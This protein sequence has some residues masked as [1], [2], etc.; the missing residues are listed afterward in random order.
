MLF[1]QLKGLYQPSSVIL[2]FALENQDLVFPVSK[3]EFHYCYAKRNFTTVC[4]D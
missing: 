1:F 2:V 3:L 4:T